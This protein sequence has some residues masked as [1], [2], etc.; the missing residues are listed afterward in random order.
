LFF[1]P[2]I[3]L[4]QT[5]RVDVAKSIVNITDLTTGGTFDPGDII[6]IRVTIA[7]MPL[8]GARTI[9][10]RVQV[11]DAVPA[12]TTYIAGSMRVTTNEGITYKG[13]FSEALDTDAGTKSGNNITIN[14]GRYANATTGGRIRSDSSKPSFFNSSAIMMACYRVRINPTAPYG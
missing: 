11:F 10:D 12:N 9:V 14:M 5:Q 8:S 7:V 6:E 1:S 3:T 4:A 13:P 2:M